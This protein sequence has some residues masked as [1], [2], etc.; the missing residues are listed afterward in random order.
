MLLSWDK[1]ALGGD[2]SEALVLLLCGV[3]SSANRRLPVV[4][5]G[6]VVGA[7]PCP[8]RSAITAPTAIWVFA[9]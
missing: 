8:D 6:C 1:V 2:I 9:I 4:E 7:R 5:N 3:L